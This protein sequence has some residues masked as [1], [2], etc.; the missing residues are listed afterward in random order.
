[1]EEKFTQSFTAKELDLIVNGL[2]NMPFKDVQPLIV[3]IVDEYNKALQ[4]KEAPTGPSVDEM[5]A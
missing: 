1:M 4:A 5:L 2:G 3:R